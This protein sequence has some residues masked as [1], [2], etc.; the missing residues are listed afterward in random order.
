MISNIFLSP[1]FDMAGVFFGL[2]LAILSFPIVIL[3]E[4]IVLRLLKWASIW[5]SLFASFVIN[6]ATLTLGFFLVGPCESWIDDLYRNRVSHRVEDITLWVVLWV[7]TVIVEGAL[8][9]RINNSSPKKTWVA[10]LTMNV[11]SYIALFIWWS[12]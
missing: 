11:A 8:L 3:I 7:M 6:T 9:S 10:S 12:Q 2:M 5:R 1:P 4:V